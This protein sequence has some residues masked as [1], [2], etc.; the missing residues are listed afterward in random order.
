MADLTLD[1][2]LVRGYRASPLVGWWLVLLSALSG[3]TL[4]MLGPRSSS[5]L[6]LLFTL[7]MLKL[8]DAV[9]AGL[10]LITAG[11]EID[12]VTRLLF[13]G[14]LL[15][16]PFAMALARTA[17][18]SADAPSVQVRAAC[19]ALTS[20]AFVFCA[21][22]E[23]FSDVFVDWKRRGRKFALFS[24]GLLTVSLFEI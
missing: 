4:G 8:F 2:V 16:A 1:D 5:F 17:M 6:Q 23:L 13:V 7:F 22:G 12:M 24:L 11:P 10:V 20:G 15:A 18:L 14:H 21:V 19:E 3:V 9:S